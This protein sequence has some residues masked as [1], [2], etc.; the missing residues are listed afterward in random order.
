MSLGKNN[1]QKQKHFTNSDSSH[2][3]PPHQPG[4]ALS[5]VYNQST[6]KQNQ[7][8]QPH[9]QM[10]SRSS[11]VHAP[12]L[13]PMGHPHPSP[14]GNLSFARAQPAVFCCQEIEINVFP[15]CVQQSTRGRKRGKRVN[16]N[17]IITESR[18]AI[19]SGL[20]T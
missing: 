8:P 9:I 11:R 10:Q 5:P 19:R 1:K 16:C 7:Q 13:P 3:P 14:R 20:P 2:R 18:R 17:R 4:I 6:S 15:R 12:L